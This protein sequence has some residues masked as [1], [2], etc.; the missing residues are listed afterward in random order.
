M[1]DC[2]VIIEKSE[3]IKQGLI[4]IISTNKITKKV[5]AFDSF[6]ELILKSCSAE[7]SIIIANP[8]CLHEN[9]SKTKKT[10]K[11][12]KDVSFMAIVYS[13]IEKEIISPFDNAI[14]IDDSPTT[15]VNKIRACKSINKETTEHALTKREIE[16]LKELI[17]GN[18]NKEVAEELCLSVHTVVTHRK[19]IM[20]KTG[21]KSLSGLAVYAILNNIMDIQEIK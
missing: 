17:K 19:N 12:S 18:T 14:Y 4:N 2:I 10:Y 6:D 1:L 15:I 16:I 11:L 8:A 3:I 7:Y 5:C 9:L 13:Y 20:E 21:I